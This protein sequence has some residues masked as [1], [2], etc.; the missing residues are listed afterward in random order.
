MKTFYHI[1]YLFSFCTVP[2]LAQETNKLTILAGQNQIGQLDGHALEVAQFQQPMGLAIGEKGQ[3]LITD[4]GNENLRSYQSGKVSSIL[5]SSCATTDVAVDTDGNTYL[6]QSEC[7]RI[8]VTEQNGRTRVIAGTGVQGVSP[9]GI[10]A[11]QA[12]LCRPLGIACRDGRVY[13]T[14]QGTHSIR[15]ID[16]IGRLQTVKVR[17]ESEHVAALQIPKGLAFAPDGSLYVADPAS[18]RVQKISPEGIM[19][20]YAGADIG[21]PKEQE[22]IEDLNL[23]QPIDV[24][25]SSDGR[26][27]ITDV[28]NEYP[29]IETNPMTGLVQRIGL[30]VPLPTTEGKYYPGGLVID[31]NDMLYL[32]IQNIHQ[33]YAKKIA[34]QPELG[35]IE[36]RGNFEISISP[37][38]AYHEFAVSIDPPLTTVGLLH[39][40]SSN[41]QLQLERKLYPGAFKEQVLLPFASSAGYHVVIQAGNKLKSATV[42]L[43]QKD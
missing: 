30:E 13:F 1:I 37:N 19:S 2:L 21:C 25:V 40:Y 14:E 16:E 15:Y 28:S 34:I 38:P 17:P 7:N 36:V 20:T 33:V 41:G 27:F 18:E 11:T 5:Q 32:S 31:E 23:N 43:H 10:W 8:T 35:K 26:V 9:D 22:R 3:L 4:L 39:V 29:L 24:A 6:V 42:L 12:N